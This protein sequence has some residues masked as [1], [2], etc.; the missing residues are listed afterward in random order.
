MTDWFDALIG[1]GVGVLLGG[2]AVAVWGLARRGRLQSEVNNATTRSE[3]L[4]EQLQARA[5]DQARLKE[6]FTALGAEVLSAN[7][8]QFTELA[9]KTFQ[10]MLAD[11]RGDGEKR[12][13]AIDGLVRP[14]KDLLEKHNAA[15][16][17]IERKREVAYEG[18]QEQIKAIAA[19]HERLGSQTG[20]LVTALRRPE[21][22]GR[23]G[24]MQ[25]R[26]AVELA[27]M[28]AHCD[29]TEQPQ[30]DD[31]ESRDRPDMVVNLSGG[32]VIIVDSKVALDAYLDSLDADA[33]P[34]ALERHADQ[35]AGHVRK[36]THKRYWEQ[37]ER[38]PKLV[39]MFM[40]MESALTAAM[41]RRP[42]L[43]AQAMADHVLIATPTL[44]VALLRAVAYGWQQEDLAANARQIAAVGRELYNRLATF[45]G[46]F[47]AI[48]KAVNDAGEAYDQAVGSLEKR[49]LP[50]A[51]ELKSLHATTEDA[52]DAP[53][54][55]QVE[56]RQISAAE[57]KS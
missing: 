18:L 52:L 26:N 53:P 22:R 43:H 13:L 3:L 16:S 23:W 38:T 32:G 54:T 11:A 55:V 8:R 46:H 37:F 47:E 33:A 51:R 5:A 50:A 49:L 41:Q 36:L 2:L 34:E 56:T 20:K 28:T 9:S 48:G 24:E 17:D 29:F 39:V 27:G 30:T 4:A 15:I 10:I 45:V 57:L 31:P 6:A 35:V 1:L 19:S 42:D 7:S 14:M 25:L 21:Q 40:P 12:Q 44:L